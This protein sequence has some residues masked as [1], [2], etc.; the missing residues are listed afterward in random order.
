MKIFVVGSFPPPYNGQYIG[1]KLMDDLLKSNDYYNVTTFKWNL[2]WYMTDNARFK[3]KLKYYFYAFFNYI[4]TITVIWIKYFLKKPEALYIVPS[5]NLKGLLRDMLIYI[6]FMLGNKKIYCHIRSG[7]FKLNTSTFKT[8]YS[9]NNFKFIF[10]THILAKESLV[11]EESYEI[12]PN[13]VDEI[14][15]LPNSTIK[16]ETIKPLKVVFISN[17]F[18]SK[19]VYDII[20]AVKYFSKDEIVLNI[21]GKGEENVINHINKEI[22]G[23]SNI[24]FNGE[25]RER[26]IV[27]RIFFESDI[28]ALPTTYKIEASPR[29]IIEAMSQYCV[30]LVTNHAGIPDMVDENCAYIIDKKL[31]LRNQLKEELSKMLKEENIVQSKKMKSKQQYDKLFSYEIIRKRIFTVI[32]KD[33]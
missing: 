19:G 14:F 26:K 22:D 2:S 32:S 6:P 33:N 18:K 10:L 8:I 15:E 16:L 5:S 4:K 23:I 1:T 24:N 31:N 3:D 7:S 28:F 29:S 27:K 21:Y 12:I 17:L 11:K 13:F 25:I 20:D 9:K 30:P